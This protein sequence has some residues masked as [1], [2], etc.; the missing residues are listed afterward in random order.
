VART[1]YNQ[2]VTDYNRSAH[3]FPAGLVRPLLGFPGSL[4]LFEAKGADL[5]RPPVIPAR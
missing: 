3:S 4:P 5:E 1:R 2:A